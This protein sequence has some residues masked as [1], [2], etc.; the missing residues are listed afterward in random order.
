M[1]PNEIIVFEPQLVMRL[2]QVLLERKKR[3][4][5]ILFHD[6][7][8]QILKTRLNMHVVDVSVVITQ[9]LTVNPF[10]VCQY[11][12]CPVHSWHH[13]RNVIKPIKTN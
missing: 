3:G 9:S 7:R 8:S 11:M 10:I 12:V 6:R 2:L 5:G 13:F 4:G 1:M